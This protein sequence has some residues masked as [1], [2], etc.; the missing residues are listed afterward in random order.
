MTPNPDDIEPRLHADPFGPARIGMTPAQIIDDHFKREAT[1]NAMK[2]DHAPT[3]EQEVEKLLANVE[4][5]TPDP[6]EHERREADQARFFGDALLTRAN[7]EAIMAEPEN[8]RRPTVKVY[9]P[10]QAD[11]LHINGPLSEYVPKTR[12]RANAV[13]ATVPGK[14]KRRK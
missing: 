12:A 3:L 7:L 13:G 1:V 11:Y 14:F 4:N 2:W 6:F 8:D 9:L 10:V 5:V